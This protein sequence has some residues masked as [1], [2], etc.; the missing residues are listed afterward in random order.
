MFQD[1]DTTRLVIAFLASIALTALLCA[2]WLSLRRFVL[3]KQLTFVLVVASF[4]AGMRLFVEIEPATRDSFKD[5]LSWVV[6]FLAAAAVIRIA[7][8]LV[9]EVILPGR[10][11]R[12][13]EALPTVSVSLAYLIAAMVTIKLVWPAMEMGGVL[14]AS[15]VTSLVLGLALQPILGNFFAG[16][17]VSVEKP[18]RINDWIHVGEHDGRVIAINWRTTHVRTRENDTVIIP[19]SK[20]A[21][22]ELL[23]YFYPNPMRLEAIRV[24]V[25]YRHPPYRV[26]EVMLRAVVGVPGTLAKPTPDVFLITFGDSAIVYELRVWIEDIADQPKI[27]SLVQMNIWEEFKRS[28]I[29]IPFP[30]RTLELAPRPKTAARAADVPPAAGLFVV[31]GPEAG[32]EVPLA[33]S[34][35]LVGRSQDCQL[36]LGDHQ[37]SKEH[38]RIEWNA[39]GFVLTDLGSTHG[40]KVNGHVVTSARLQPLD[41][42]QIGETVLVFET[43]D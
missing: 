28:G 12:P 27:R 17:V 4:A 14:G 39:D 43:Y 9:F 36:V 8:L 24:G 16:F 18:F 2:V 29:A 23:N 6:I 21:D 22:G 10:G 35:A 25:H 13:P 37:V 33:A 32:T 1:G 42:I 31:M 38:V 15:A 40:T 11:F 20:V 26:R 5:A 19:N 41:R 30:I 34:P 7:S 3:I